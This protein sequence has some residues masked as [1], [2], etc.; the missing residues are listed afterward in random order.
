V[1]VISTAISAAVSPIKAY[2]AG[3]ILVAVIGSAAVFIHHERALGAA[4]VVAADKR[5]ALVAA[6]KDKAI[7]AAENAASNTAS[8]VYEKVVSLP[9][10]DDIGVVCQRAPAPVSNVLP[11]A[12]TGAQLPV[13]VSGVG[14]AYDPS[15]ALLTRARDADAEIAALLADNAAMRKAMNASP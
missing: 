5:T 1:T 11:E 7:E 12:P 15:G 6:A 4:E 14:P 8:Q 9:S 10:V 2:I 13:T 3:G